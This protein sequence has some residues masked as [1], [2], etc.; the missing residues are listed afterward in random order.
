MVKLYHIGDC[1]KARPLTE[2]LTD[3]LIRK[4]TVNTVLV[5]GADDVCCTRGAI[6]SMSG[7]TSLADLPRLV[8]TVL[9]ALGNDSAPKH[10]ASGG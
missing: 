10:V 6:A 1:V 8:S 3:L 7:K 5:C 9:C 2:L 4:N